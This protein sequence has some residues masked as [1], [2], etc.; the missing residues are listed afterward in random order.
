MAPLNYPLE[1][2]TFLQSCS[3]TLS[4][5]SYLEIAEK[6]GFWSISSSGKIIKKPPVEK[7]SANTNKLQQTATDNGTQEKKAHQ[8]IIILKKYASTV[9]CE[10]ITL[11]DLRLTPYTCR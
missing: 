8:A 6:T 9:S 2:V 4:H 5:V 11:K 3:L 1:E 10:I 7:I